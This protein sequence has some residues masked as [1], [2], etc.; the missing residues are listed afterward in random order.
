MNQKTKTAI[1]SDHG[2]SPVQRLAIVRT[3]ADLFLTGSFGKNGIEIKTN[4]QENS[5]K[6]SVCSMATI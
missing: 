2:L 4:K 5:S 1:G 3:N 6:D